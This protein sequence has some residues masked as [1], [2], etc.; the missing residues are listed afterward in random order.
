MMTRP[1][2]PHRR[3]SA[4]AVN[5]SRRQA[6]GTARGTTAARQDIV[7]RNRAVWGMG[8]SPMLNKRVPVGT[9]TPRI[10][11]DELLRRDHAR[12]RAQVEAE[13]R[14]MANDPRVI[15]DRIDREVAFLS[16]HERVARELDALRAAGV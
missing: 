14:D 1:K 12:L 2:K 7:K 4:K 11:G 6:H 3:R 10:E 9:D 13:A 16:F 5:Q 8:M 15:A